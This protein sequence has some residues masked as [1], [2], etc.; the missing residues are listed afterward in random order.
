MTDLTHEGARL[1]IQMIQQAIEEE[2]RCAMPRVERLERMV[3]KY[4]DQTQSQGDF[5][6]CRDLLGEK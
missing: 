2:R 1:V 3:R 4:M 5:D 6:E